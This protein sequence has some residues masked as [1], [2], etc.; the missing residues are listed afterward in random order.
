MNKAFRKFGQAIGEK[1]G[2]LEATE[3]E[4]DFITLEAYTDHVRHGLEDVVGATEE[5]LIPDGA[6]RK[7]MKVQ[8]SRKYKQPEGVL[9]EA[10]DKTSRQIGQEIGQMSATLEY[11]G[12]V[13]RQIADARTQMDHDVTEQFLDPVRQFLKGEMQE[14]VNHKK[15]FKSRRLDYD[16]K[17]R[18]LDKK[19]DEKTEE[20]YRI[21]EGKFEESK[22]LAM[23]GMVQ[24]QNGEAE[25]ISQL[26]AFVDAQKRFHESAISSLASLIDYLD[27][28]INTVS[29]GTKREYAPSARDRKSVV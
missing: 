23:Q 5:Y 10:L 16:V 14:V 22:E 27:Q 13:Q 17:K 9:S 19:R 29:S 28:Q 20:A 7:L 1:T 26:R 11:M 4:Q 12:Q 2:R 21:A 18:D 24:L 25:Q 15:K 3:I 8:K 6:I